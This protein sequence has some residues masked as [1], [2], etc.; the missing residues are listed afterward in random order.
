MGIKY[1]QPGRVD[2]FLRPAEFPC[3]WPRRGRTPSARRCAR[4]A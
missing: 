2:A 3:V 1:I 4:A